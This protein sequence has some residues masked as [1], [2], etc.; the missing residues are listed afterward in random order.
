MA[1]PN[2]KKKI[3][4]KQVKLMQNTEQ[5]EVTLVANVNNDRAMA[6]ATRSKAKTS[7]QT[8]VKTKKQLTEQ[9]P[10]K[11]K[12]T[13]KIVFDEIESSKGKAIPKKKAKRL[14]ISTKESAVT[15]ANF[16]EDQHDME[17]E[18][19]AQEEDLFPY[20]N[21]PKPSDTETDSSSDDSDSEIILS[22]QS[23][24]MRLAQPENVMTGESKG[25]D[26]ELSQMD[27]ERQNSTQNKLKKIDEEMALKLRQLK[28]MMVQGGLNESVEVIDSCLKLS[29][30]D[31]SK[32]KNSNKGNNKNVKDNHRAI[33]KLPEASLAANLAKNLVVKDGQFGSPSEE[34]IYK[35]AIDKRTTDSSDE[36]DTSDDFIHVLSF[37]DVILGEGEQTENG[38]VARESR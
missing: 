18:V 11:R 10:K 38:S 25:S 2:E 5:D 19:H 16:M 26:E 15:T 22:S 32:S 23:V 1:K 28:E 35:N 31:M 29:S 4:K 6:V 36:I 7:Q 24:L 20:E 13:G 17:M 33:D 14:Q 21:N 9:I 30:Q 37:D 3:A 34:T 8:P 12:S 27:N